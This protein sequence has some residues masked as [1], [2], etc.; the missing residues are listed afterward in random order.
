MDGADHAGTGRGLPRVGW[1]VLPRPRLSALIADDVTL[2]VLRA[3]QGFGK[4]TLLAQWLRETTGADEVRLWLDVGARVT[5]INSFWAEV[6]ALLSDYGLVAGAVVP[7][8]RARTSVARAIAGLRTPVVLALDDYDALPEGEADA[9]LLALL[10]SNSLLRLVVCVRTVRLLRRARL[11]AVQ[12]RELTEQDLAFTAAETQELVIQAGIADQIRL[13]GRMHAE[14]GGWPY[15][16]RALILFALDPL[17]A[18]G[19]AGGDPEDPAEAVLDLVLPTLAIFGLRDTALT[20]S[21]VGSFTVD[22][23]EHLTGVTDGSIAT[24]LRHLSTVGLVSEEASDRFVTYRWRPL[25]RAAL[26]MMLHREDGD[27]AAGLE[28][29]AAAWSLEHAT[30]AEALRL[31]LAA[32]DWD[33]AVAAIERAGEDL[34]VRY[35]RLLYDAVVAIPPEHF[36]RSPYA[37]AVRAARL[38]AADEDTWVRLPR[39]PADEGELAV[40]AVDTDLARTLSLAAM[41]TRA[42]RLCGRFTE[43]RDQAERIHTLAGLAGAVGGTKPS[44]AAASIL[45][46]AATTF[47][48][49][50]RERQ[51]IGLLVTVLDIEGI[52]EGPGGPGRATTAVQLALAHAVA[53]NPSRAQH[54]LDHAPAAALPS[55]RLD[56]GTAAIARAAQTIASVDRLSAPSAFDDGDGDDEELDEFWA[57][58]AFARSLRALHTGTP[59]VGLAQVNEANRQ[60]RNLRGSGSTAGPMLA[61]I[62]AE[63]LL[64]L[65]QANQAARVLHEADEGHP[66]LRVPAARLA[67]LTGDQHKTITLAND[68]SWMAAANLRQSTTMLLLKALAHHRLGQHAV[69][70][71]TLGNALAAAAPV[72]LLSPFTTVPHAELLDVASTLPDDLSRPLRSERLERAA[73]PFPRSAALLTLTEQEQRVIKGL[74]SGALVRDIA[75]EMFIAHNTAK[76]HLQNL[77]RKLGATSRTEA[78]AIASALGILGHSGKP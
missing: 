48:L 25:V 65:G 54:Y 37:S 39:L 12:T 28:A 68:L 30:S 45:G 66:G 76:R 20:L 70:A 64:A 56:R 69:A 71:A 19:L 75:A 44:T 23:A 9:D 17:S 24:A 62:E 13:A 46:E 34:L 52:D 16:T 11:S 72:G 53:G 74:A 15:L 50:G 29:A 1:L 10:Q 67:L 26:S 32:E 33:T 42:L 3:P 57:Y 36:H 60:H 77:Y 59:F 51:A 31:A 40:L 18:R 41:V 63:L 22:L 8:H 7:D 27:R 21:V 73:E 78:V 55:D 43:A 49:A 58:L 61:A 5:D 35:R 14:T 47:Q 38:R 4:S 2:T 6:L